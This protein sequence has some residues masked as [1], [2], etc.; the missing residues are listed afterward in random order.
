MSV[1]PSDTRGYFKG[2]LKTRASLDPVDAT[3]WFTGT[4]YSYGRPEGA[5]RLFS[6]DGVNVARV[7]QWANGYRM[8]SREAGVYRSP[9]SGE[10]LRRWTNPFTGAELDVIHLW[11][12]PVNSTYDFDRP[13][14]R[15][16]AKVYETEDNVAFAF[17]ALI[18]YPSPLPVADY[19]KNSGDD[20]YRAAELLQ[21]I[22]PRAELEDASRSSSSCVVS[23]TRLSQ[24]LPWMEM[25][26]EGGGL[27]YHCH[28][29]KLPEGAAGLPAD[30]RE[31]LEANGP[32]Y[33]RAPE[34]WE[35]PNETSWTYFK[36]LRHG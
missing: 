16:G 9:E 34:G 33:L 36:H 26:A 12:D 18:D 8:L 13:P 7:E 28:G 25:G 15:F 31:F 23:W 14:V 5:R 21:F 24:W 35:E 2:F 27:L 32:R 29:V 10:I 6:F 17:D 11:N 4:I 19:P 1:D 30:F 20:T 22:S 3:V